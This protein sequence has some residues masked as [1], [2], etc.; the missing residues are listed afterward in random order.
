MD[1]SQAK[2]WKDEKM[3][4]LSHWYSTVQHQFTALSAVQ[5]LYELLPPPTSKLSNM[6]GESCRETIDIS[7]MSQSESGPISNGFIK[8]LLQSENFHFEKKYKTLNLTKYEHLRNL[9]NFESAKDLKGRRY[10]Q[11]ENEER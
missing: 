11:L 7:F 5:A 3:P 2:K 9:S 8:M 4:P 1:S 6:H 10:G